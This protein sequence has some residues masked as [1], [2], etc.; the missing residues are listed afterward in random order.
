MG[1]YPVFSRE[2]WLDVATRLAVDGK[3]LG[4]CPGHTCAQHAV[5]GKLQPTIPGSPRIDGKVLLL[6]EE[7]YAC[8]WGAE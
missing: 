8:R 5:F 6:G 4:L 3:N 1:F 7:L 2:R